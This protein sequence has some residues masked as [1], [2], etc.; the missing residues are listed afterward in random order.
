MARYFFFASI[1]VLSSGCA[2]DGVD[3]IFGNSGA[4]GDGSGGAGQQAS[5]SAAETSDVVTSTDSVTSVTNAT[6]TDAVT[7]VTATTAA[8]TATTTS[9]TTGG[10]DGPTVFCNGQ[11]CDAGDV[12]CFNKFT[13]GQDYCSGPGTCADGGEWAELACNGP[14]DCNGGECCGKYDPQQGWTELSCKP[15]CGNDIVMC[16]GAPLACDLGEICHS[17][18]SLGTGY[19]Y[20][21]N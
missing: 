7:D 13:A 14:D 19:Q 3:T 9:V 11:M 12:C 21:G 5:N 16:Y 17:S 6:A 15:N 1:L 20:C 18:Q 8:T 10:G 4:G 2:V